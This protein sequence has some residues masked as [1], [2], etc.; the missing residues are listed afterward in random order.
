[1]PTPSIVLLA[2][3][4]KTPGGKDVTATNNAEEEE[5]AVGVADNQGELENNEV[6]IQVARSNLSSPQQIDITT[7]P[8]PPLSH[9]AGTDREVWENLPEEDRQP[10]EEMASKA[11]SANGYIGN[12]P[13][14]YKTFRK[15]QKIRRD[16]FRAANHPTNYVNADE[17]GERDVILSPNSPFYKDMM[18][19]RFNILGRARNPERENKACDEVFMSL[20]Q[21][22]GEGGKFYKCSNT[23]MFYEV[24]DVAA[25]ASKFD[26][27]VLDDFSCINL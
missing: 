23:M 6:V 7:A 9:H 14:A 22:M 11:Y 13:S 18:H 12:K 15:E 24:D 16:A 2:K 10:Y 21:T 19:R 27:L 20:K 17:I 5:V 25:L 1:M 3:G 4:Q 8:K 26:E